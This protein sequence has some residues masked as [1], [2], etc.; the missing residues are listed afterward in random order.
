MKQ[1]LSEGELAFANQIAIRFRGVRSVVRERVEH[2]NRASIPSRADPGRSHRSHAY[3]K[4]LNLSAIRANSVKSARRTGHSAEQLRQTELQD[5]DEPLA[6][7][8]RTVCFEQ[9]LL[10]RRR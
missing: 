9:S 4:D 8:Q 5:D 10:L 3:S 7:S 1:R 6:T 2:R